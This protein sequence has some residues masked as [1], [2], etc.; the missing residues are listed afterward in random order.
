MLASASRLTPAFLGI[1]G[2]AAVNGEMPLIFPLMFRAASQRSRARWA[3]NQNSELLPNNRESRNAISGLTARRSRSNSFTVWRDTRRD[4]ANPD[5]VKPYSGRKSSRSVIPG[6]V[7]RTF[8]GRLLGMLIAHL[9]SMVIRYFYVVRV[10][11]FKSKAYLPLIVN[12][13]RILPKPV[14][15]QFVKSI[16]RRHFQIIQARSEMKIFQFAQCQLP[17]SWRNPLGF[18]GLVELLCTLVGKGLD[19]A[20]SVMWC[21]TPI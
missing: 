15:L 7:G 13:N 11:S 1:K 5:T 18:T 2:Y 17:H 14:A 4:L 9:S 19:H 6:C 21:V 16:A 20:R 10:A 8:R 12:G 3:F